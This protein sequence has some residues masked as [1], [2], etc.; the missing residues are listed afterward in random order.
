MKKAQNGAYISPALGICFASPYKGRFTLNFSYSFIFASFLYSNPNNTD[1]I[2][3]TKNIFMRP[4]L[5][6]GMLF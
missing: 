4:A 6:L 5:S 3:P 2:G 1:F